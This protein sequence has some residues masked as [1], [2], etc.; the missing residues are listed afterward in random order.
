MNHTTIE[1][2]IQMRLTK[3]AES[4]RQQITD[5]QFQDLS[6]EERFGMLVD[7]EWSRRRHNKLD[8]LIMSA[9]FRYPQACIEDIDYHGDRKLDKDQILRLAGCGY[10][11]QRHNL[12][13]MG[14]AGNGKS[15]LGCAFGMAACRNYYSVRYI[16]LPELLDDLAIARGEGSY[17]KV[18]R[19]YKKIRLLILDE[20]LLSPL[21]DTQARELLELIEARYQNA[22]T[23]FCS[24]FPPKEWYDR[25]GEMTLADAILDRIVHDSHTIFI[26]GQVSMRERLG[27]SKKKD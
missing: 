20:W 16:R 10:I 8:R 7:H 23:V 6:F 24:Q 21:T 25:I 17:K 27:I 2:L 19:Q 4:F 12:I 18:M 9:K 22:S 26:D 11:E 5:N 1:K 13:I 3:M 14:A 15:Y